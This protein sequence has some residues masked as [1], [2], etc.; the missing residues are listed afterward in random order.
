MLFEPRRKFADYE[1][2]MLAFEREPIKKGLIMLYGDSYFTRW[3]PKYGN[4][5]AEDALLGKDGK[6]AVVN[7]GFGGSA[8]EDLLYYYHRAV[9]PWAPRA[10]VIKSFGNDASS[11]YTP[12]EILFLLYRL[13]DYARTDFPGIKLYLCGAMPIAKYKSFPPS[14]NAAMKDFDRELEAYCRG[15]E[16][17]TFVDLRN[18][19]FIYSDPARVGD[20]SSIREDLYIEDRAHFNEKGYGLFRN[21]ML[22]VLGDVL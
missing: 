4:E 5:R 6:Q 8:V 22:G 15:H 2:D 3:E 18:C 11:G 1:E 9:K 10:L 20:I 19:P 12:L 14:R 13:A 17:S 16:D 21:Y 7:H